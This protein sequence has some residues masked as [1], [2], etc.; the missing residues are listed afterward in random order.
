M[1]DNNISTAFES[2]PLSYQKK[3]IFYVPEYFL[4]DRMFYVGRIQCIKYASY[5]M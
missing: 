3:L 2:G 4:L 5:C 1:N